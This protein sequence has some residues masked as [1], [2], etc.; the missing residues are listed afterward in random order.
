MEQFSHSSG[1]LPFKAE[2]LLTSKLRPTFFLFNFK[3]EIVIWQ[4]AAFYPELFMKSCK[5]K[6][7][8]VGLNHGSSR[9]EY[10]CANH[11]NMQV[12]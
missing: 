11:Y 2:S 6:K 4:N 1:I 8:C 5:Q 3:T 7:V 9:V 10:K 12:V